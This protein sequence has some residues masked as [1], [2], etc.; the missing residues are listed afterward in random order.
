MKL[1]YAFSRGKGK[2]EKSLKVEAS[3]RSLPQRFIRMLQKTMKDKRDVP[4][5]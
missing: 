5:K 2:M 4:N 3:V 1:A